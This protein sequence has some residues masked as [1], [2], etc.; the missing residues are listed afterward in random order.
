VCL[1][2]LDTGIDGA[3]PAFKELITRENYVDFTGTGL[4]DSTGH[5][6]HCAGIVF[7]RDVGGVRIG[8]ARGAERVLVAKIADRSATTTTETLEKAMLWAVERGAD[9]IS[10]SVGI[11]FLGHARRLQAE[12]VPLDAAIAQA[13]SDYRDYARFFD[14]LVGR[15]VSAGAAGR[16]ALVV[17][18]AGNDSRADGV[19]SYRVGATLPAVAEGVLSVGAVGRS[20]NGKLVIAPFSNTGANVC[21]PGVGILSALPGGGTGRMGAMTGTSQA[22]PHAAGVAALWWEK[23]RQETFERPSPADVISRLRGRADFAKL[24]PPLEVEAVGQGLV[25]S[26]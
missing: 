24:S 1:A 3:H 23:I 11:D 12:G 7:G 15:V 22:A 18:A 4:D 6:T 5:G 8:V 2:V 10:M 19:P 21:A 13:L 16:S 17:A 9:V 25:T 26:P 14:R 20:V